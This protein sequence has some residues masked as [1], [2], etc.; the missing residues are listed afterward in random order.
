MAW[1]LDSLVAW[2]AT[3]PAALGSCAGSLENRAAGT[4]DLG[5]N[6]PGGRIG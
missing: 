3:Y 2:C 4:I 6:G 5:R 1:A